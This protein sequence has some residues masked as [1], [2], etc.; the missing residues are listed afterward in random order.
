MRGFLV[1]LTRR[2]SCY[3]A[4]FFIVVIFVG[5]GV[6]AVFVFLFSAVDVSLRCFI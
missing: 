2:L 1:G 5:D 4:F 3:I 6:F